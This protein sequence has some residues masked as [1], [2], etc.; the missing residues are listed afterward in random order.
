MAKKLPRLAH[1]KYVHRKG[2]VYAYFNTG[3]KNDKGNPIRVA[4]PHP[5]EVGFFDSYAALKAGR[6]KRMKVRY[7]VSDLVKDY[8]ASPNFAKRPDSTKRSYRLHANKIAETWGEFPADDLQPADVRRAIEGDHWSAGTGHMVH[9]LLGVLYRWGRRNKGLAIDPVRDVERPKY[10]EHEPWPAHVVDAALASEDNTIR[11]AVS[12]LYFT[13]QRIGDVCEMRWSDIRDGMIH[14]KQGKT[15]KTVE[16]PLTAELRAELD[17][18]PRNG[19]TII[20]GITQRQLRRKLQVFTAAMGAKTVPHGLRKNA[21]NALLEAGCTV[22]EV[23]AIT[24]QTHQVVEHYAARVNR[25]KLGGAA[26]L[27]L[28]VSRARGKA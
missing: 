12:L 2:R 6:T 19:M 17:R 20:T 9:A 28:D 1:L 22:P 7:L 25:R 16:P 27:K 14:V 13:G 11:L 24:G 23:S 18:T 10:G 26:I 15:G 21:V 3:K 4:M 8:L 5:S